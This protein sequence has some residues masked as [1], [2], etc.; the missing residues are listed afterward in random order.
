M[1]KGQGHKSLHGCFAAAALLKLNCL[2][3]YTNIKPVY[4]R[5][6]PKKYNINVILDIDL[7][8]DPG[9]QH[10]RIVAQI[11]SHRSREDPNQ[12]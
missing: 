11:K 2:T 1:N 7:W 8:P 3:K 9:A 6:R 4:R 12:I 10:K 5:I